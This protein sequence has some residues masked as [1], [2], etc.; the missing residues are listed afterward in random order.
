MA[1]KEFE[2]IDV[3]AILD[4][5]VTP[6]TVRSEPYNAMIDIQNLCHSIVELEMLFFK[7]QQNIRDMKNSFP[8][9]R[10]SKMVKKID[11]ATLTD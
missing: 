8:K 1:D 2:K 4:K 6:A 5:W 9:P 10:Q 3:A 7:A 11:L